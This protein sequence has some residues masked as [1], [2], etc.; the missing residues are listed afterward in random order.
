MCKP[1]I[2]CTIVSVKARATF[3]SIDRGTEG[4]RRTSTE[5]DTTN[6]ATVHMDTVAVDRTVQL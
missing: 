3:K 1:K 5:V 6:D 2:A 4:V